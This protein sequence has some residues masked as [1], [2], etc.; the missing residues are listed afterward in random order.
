MGLVVAV[1]VIEAQHAAIVDAEHMGQEEGEIVSSHLALCVEPDLLA[2]N[3]DPTRTPETSLIINFFAEADPSTHEKI[4]TGDAS[5]ATSVPGSDSC[6]RK[7]K[8]RWLAGLFVS[9]SR[10]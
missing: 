9:S 8:A 7:Q 3:T 1:C 10:S 6:L 5:K 4:L 2:K